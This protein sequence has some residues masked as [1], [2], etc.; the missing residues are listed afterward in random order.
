MAE[1]LESSLD[2]ESAGK[3]EKEEAAKKD[4]PEGLVV[5]LFL[6]PCVGMTH[7]VAVGEYN[8]TSV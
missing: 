5:T 1:S 8:T 4:E 2:R 3:K 6:E 7:A